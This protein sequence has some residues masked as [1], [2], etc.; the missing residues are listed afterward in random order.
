MLCCVASVCANLT[1]KGRHFTTK[2]MLW[3]VEVPHVPISHLDLELMLQVRG[4]EISHTSSF[5]ESPGVS[6][7]GLFDLAA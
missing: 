7:A 3:A 2:A 1:F 5:T 4:A 6:I